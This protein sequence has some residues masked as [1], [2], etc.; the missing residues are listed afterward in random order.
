M[1]KDFDEYF[2][3]VIGR[4]FNFTKKERMELKENLKNSIARWRIKGLI[5]K[6][7]LPDAGG[8]LIWDWKMYE[9]K[10]MTIRL[11]KS[12]SKRINNY[13]R[14]MFGLKDSGANE[15]YIHHMVDIMMREGM[16]IRYPDPELIDRF[17]G[18][19]GIE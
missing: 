11:V 13:R 16:P 10:L 4:G 8:K 6:D 5:G 12:L 19:D 9:D 7:E 14:K 1:K 2:N 3:E 15:I 18:G 17:F